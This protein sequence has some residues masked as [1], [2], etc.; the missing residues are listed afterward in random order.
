MPVYG[1]AECSVALCLPAGGPRA[2]GRPR[3]ARALRD[4]RAR[5]EAAAPGD[6]G[7]ARVRL[8]GARAAR[9]R[10]PHRR[11]RRRATLAERDGGP[12]RVPRALDD[13]AATT[14]S[15]R[16]PP[17]SRSRAAGSTAAT[18]PTAPTARSTSAAG[19]R[20]SSSRAA[21]TSC[22]RRSRRPRPTVEGVRRGCVVAFGVPNAALGTEAPGGGGGDPRR[23]TPRER[24][25]LAGAVTERVAAAVDV[26]PDQVVLV[27]PGAV[28]KTSSGKVRRAATRELYLAGAL[29]RPPRTTLAP[30]GAAR[31]R[32]RSPRRVRPGSRRA[33]GAPLR[34]LARARRCR[35]C[36]S[37]P[38]SLVAL[39]PEPPLRLRARRASPCA[40]ACGSPAAAS[41]SR[42]SS[43]C[44]ATGRS[45]C[46]E[47][48]LL[49]RRR[50][51]RS[52]CCPPTSCSWPSARCSAIPLVGA[53]VRR[54]GHLTVDRWDALQSVADADARG[55]GARARAS[56]VLLLPRGHL[57]RGRRACGRSGWA[58]SWPRR[59]RARPS[60]RSPCAARAAC[61]AATGACPGPG[62]SSLWVG[63]PDRARGH[64]HG[65]ARRL[66]DRVADAIA[67]HCG[68]PRLDLV[69]AGPERARRGL[70]RA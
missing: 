43:A 6:A 46:L 29:G 49:R 63:E 14:G 18:S 9:A 19:A 33:R 42:A 35:S 28:P 66:R 30:E 1:L 62:G 26:P 24:E 39:V 65:G 22:R 8:G 51:A 56:D 58:P 50:R 45:C 5:A 32:P 31:S 20:T 38:G 10:G 48:R 36:S 54:C 11:R 60:S 55:A 52:R 70:S 2:A 61:C 25:R 41:R 68:E 7:R 64:R 69:A 57:R 16:R 67:A 12:A 15:P 17:R 40:R 53:F 37:P 44:R 3:R 4:A 47:P 23:A 59:A 34:R 21:A 13:R 27:P